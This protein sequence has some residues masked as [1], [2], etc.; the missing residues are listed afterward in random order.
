MAHCMHLLRFP[1]EDPKAKRWPSPGQGRQE[2]GHRAHPSHPSTTLMGES[3]EAVTLAPP[4]GIRQERQGCAEV[5]EIGSL[6]AVPAVCAGAPPGNR[7]GALF[8]YTA[9][10]PTGHS[11]P[12]ST[13]STRLGAPQEWSGV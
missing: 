11:N 4:C 10:A 5:W 9:P 7:L 2:K 8:T 12:I 13:S 6:G 3:G 1:C